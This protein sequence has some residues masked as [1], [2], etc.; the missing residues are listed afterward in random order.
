MTEGKGL[1]DVIA[2]KPTEE[3][4]AEWGKGFIPPDDW[5]GLIYK[6]MC[7]HPERR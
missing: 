4:D 5:V 6:R 7:S 3:F 2:M 1:G